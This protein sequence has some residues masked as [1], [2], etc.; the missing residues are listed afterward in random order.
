MRDMLEPHELLVGSSFSTDS[1]ADI[2]RAYPQVITRHMSWGASLNEL[3][4]LATGDVSLFIHADTLGPPSAASATWSALE[5]PGVVGGAFQLRR[6][7]LGRVTHLIARSVSLRTTL[8]N[9]F[10]GDQA[11]FVQHEVFARLERTSARR[12][13]VGHF[14]RWFRI[15]WAIATVGGLNNA[16]WYDRRTS[17]D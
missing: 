15:T 11:M 10:S 2:T 17:H 5:E 16:V 7:D 9:T 12:I 13:A 4:S 1:M 14:G 8:L 6:D 3:A